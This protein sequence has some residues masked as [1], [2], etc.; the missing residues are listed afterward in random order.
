MKLS[1]KF[2]DRIFET[3]PPHEAIAT[4]GQFLA[5]RINENQHQPDFGLTRPELNVQLYAVYT[6]E[7]GNGGHMQFFLNPSGN[8]A[9]A[10]LKSLREMNL[11]RLAEILARAM[12]VFPG[13]QFESDPDLREEII[14]SLPSDTEAIWGRCDQEVF[15][16]S[17]RWDAQILE[18]MR[19]NRSH[20]LQPETGGQHAG[21]VSSEVAP[22][23]GPDEPSA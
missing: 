12:A 9:R 18:Y 13:E 20:F 14:Q 11:T 15:G 16:N 22:S 2:V 17:T 3:Y 5:P 8:L 6:C 21:Q 4:V 19:R 10:T 23:A 7:V 1:P